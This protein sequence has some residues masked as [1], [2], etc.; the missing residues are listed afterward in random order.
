ITNADATPTRITKMDPTSEAK[1][2]PVDLF[3]TGFSP[4]AGLNW[5]YYDDVRY[6]IG[7]VISDNK[8]LSFIP[9]SIDPGNYQFSI[10]T[11]Y[12]ATDYSE[13]I[14]VLAP[15]EANYQIEN[16][17]SIEANTPSSVKTGDF[18][19]DGIIDI[20]YGSEVDGTVSWF[21]GNGDGTFGDATLISGSVPNA[22][23]LAIADIDNDGD[24]DIIAGAFGSNQ[25][26]VF[27]NFEGTGFS[28]GNV[29]SS[30][31]AGVFTLDTGDFNNDGFVDIVAGEFN[32]G[33]IATLLNNGNGTFGSKNSLGGSATNVTSVQAVD[34][35]S[36]G[37]LD[38]LSASPGDN[39]VAWYENN[40][41]GNFS[42]QQ[43]I[44]T[45]GSGVNTAFAYDMNRDGLKDII[46]ISNSDES[47]RIYQN[48]GS[49]FSS[50][51]LTNNAQD[52]HHIEA[53]DINGDGY[54]DIL[55]SSNFTNRLYYMLNDTTD[56][57]DFQA[58]VE[59]PG[60]VMDAYTFITKDLD[61]NGFLDII[62]A[63]ADGSD[64]HIHYHGA[65]IST[66]PNPVSVPVISSIT[67][68]AG[69][70]GS[71]ILL[72][73]INFSEIPD[74]NVVRFNGT[75][76]TVLGG[77]TSKLQV[78]VPE[79]LFGQ[80]TI[81]IDHPQVDVEY[82]EPFRVLVE[83][84]ADYENPFTTSGYNGEGNITTAD[85]DGNGF[86][87]LILTRP[88]FN[89]ISMLFSDGNNPFDR[90]LS[91][92]ITDDISPSIIK[93]INLDDQDYP[94]FVFISDQENEFR[95]LRNTGASP[96]SSSFMTQHTITANNIQPTDVAIAD[97]DQ[98]GRSDVII[99]SEDLSKISWYSNET[100]ETD[101]IFGNEQ[102]VTTSAGGVSAIYAADFNADGFTDVVAGLAGA[103]LI[104]L[105]TN[106]GSGSFNTSF[107][108]SFGSVSNPTEIT[109]AD[110]D[111]DG[112]L[113]VIAS[114]DG[115]I[116]TLDNNGD[117]SFTNFT[118]IANI[119]NASDIAV[120]DINGD[121]RLDVIASSQST[122]EYFWLQ[123]NG[124]IGFSSLEL[125]PGTYSGAIDV[126]VYDM[127]ANGQLDVAVRGANN[128]ILSVTRSIFQ[129]I[130]GGA[131]VQILSFSS[132]NQVVTD[133]DQLELITNTDFSSFNNAESWFQSSLRVVNSLET[134]FIPSGI[135]V[136]GSSVL[137]DNSTLF[138]AD[139]LNVIINANDLNRN[140]N[141]ALYLDTNQNGFQD[142]G[143]DD[144]T[145]D[146]FYTTFIGDFNNDLDVD[147]NDLARFREGWRTDDFNFETAPLDFSNGNDFPRAILTPDNDFNIDD[148]VAFIRYWNLSQRVNAKQKANMLAGLN[149]GQSSNEN[150]QNSS[151]LDVSES[152]KFIG[153]EE[154]DQ[155]PQYKS[156]FENSDNEFV[157]TFSLNHPDKVMALSLTLDYDESK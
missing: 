41:V 99:A 104:A 120:G 142:T 72:T 36:D 10:R 29:E 118:V 47:I 121:T 21:K 77:N 26:I 48:D 4:T 46:A 6:E 74:Q 101:V 143:E 92:S 63:A 133:K 79:G 127:D 148:L 90:S 81:S 28:S 35:D 13:L 51:V 32:S 151:K 59:I 56:N 83:N 96:T 116:V 155:S 82:A 157:Y 20:V 57:F 102:V 76:A 108:T 114:A 140:S 65:D 60:E 145:S 25:I 85:I 53:G 113:D 152:M 156:D 33:T 49:T 8:L 38:I 87:D 27:E 12:G 124:N 93:P 71:N 153:F 39:K 144:Y 18:D 2:V 40:G 132:A 147:I 107:L 97:M 105:Y 146:P 64:I 42:F 7:Y 68:S 37:D 11:P 5:L 15:S 89:R 95:V 125:F 94:D 110:L 111:D 106:T 62:S 88:A 54:L 24:L 100:T 117:G 69:V 119:Q 58:P 91:I 154:A 23:S 80:A 86:D 129:P 45:E 19:L 14:S 115:S 22:R 30:T 52:P 34:L 130:T 84:S 131:G 50:Q 126:E 137:I 134:N 112:D 61:S 141:G 136:N 66:E 17:K 149:S 78:E 138:R 16:F 128:G 75:Q 109:A 1:G 122:G 123:N 103:E 9:S 55:Y 135:T 3:G 67:P 150:L 98:D 139:T 70:A 43:V 73:G 44:S 31:A